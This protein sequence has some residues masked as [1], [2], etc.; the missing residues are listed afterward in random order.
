MIIHIPV[1]SGFENALK[2]EL[3]SL[4]YGKA[5]VINGRARLEG[6]EEDVARLNL[7]LRVGE[8]VLIEFSKF[9]ASTFDE[10]FDGTYSLPWEKV[11]SVDSKILMD[12]KSM[13]STLGAIKAM[14]GVMKK[15]IIRRLA[16]KKGDR[17]TFVET[18]ARV[19][20]GFFAYKDEITITL[21]SSGD[22]LHKRG[23]RTLSYTAPLKETTAAGLIA[24][25]FYHPQKDMEKPFADIFCGSGTLPIEAALIARNIAP[26]K[27]RN[28]DFEGWKFFPKE[29]IK[30]ARQEA[31]DRENLLVKPNVFASDISADAISISRYHAKRAGVED[32]IRF[33]KM[34]MRS[35]SSEQKYGVL[36]SNPPYGERLS[37]IEEVKELYHDLG[38][39][40]RSL[41]E[42]SGYFLTS[43]AEF[44]RYFGKS[45][46]RK[47][48]IS[49][50][51]LDC[52]FY[53]YFG[54]KPTL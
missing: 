12:G 11:L 43:F 4:G 17:R 29:A 8:R 25:T 37:S 3:L 16:D 54:E 31:L 24:S 41:P 5:P 36:I 18:G 32:C 10:L 7:F 6:T 44:E 39:V 45:A 22:G 42:W 1:Q 26:G 38:K 9:H 53:S 47:K 35:F 30:R 51:N 50:A 20:V 52:T 28:F 33:E 13:L 23:Y 34:D 19:I 14:G 40:F 49:N 2:G 15:A 48:K 46:N 27:G 21:D